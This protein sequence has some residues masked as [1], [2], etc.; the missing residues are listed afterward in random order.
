M[1]RRKMKKVKTNIKRIRKYS[2]DF[3]PDQKR[4]AVYRYFVSDIFGDKMREKRVYLSW[5][6]ENA[7]RSSFFDKD[8]VGT[9]ST[10]RSEESLG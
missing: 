6:F 8:N 5:C 1:Y 2:Y 10:T 3:K 7:A 9:N 4:H